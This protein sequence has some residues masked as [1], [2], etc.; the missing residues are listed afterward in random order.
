MGSE[1]FISSHLALGLSSHLL[2]G[3]DSVKDVLRQRYIDALFTGIRIAIRKARSCEAPS[4]GFGDAAGLAGRACSSLSLGSL[5]L[6]LRGGR[7]YFRRDRV[8][9]LIIFAAVAMS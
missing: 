2:L 6:R 9:M 5:G 1:G 3:L 7:E 8:L 4:R